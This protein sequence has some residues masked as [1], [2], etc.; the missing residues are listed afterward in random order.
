MH[1]LCLR[2]QMGAVHL[3]LYLTMG[4]WSQLIMPA[5]WLEDKDWGLIKSCPQNR[6]RLLKVLQIIRL[7][8]LISGPM[9]PG[10]LTPIE[11]QDQTTVPNPIA[12][13]EKI[14][15]TVSLVVIMDIFFILNQLGYCQMAIASAL[16]DASFLTDTSVEIFASDVVECMSHSLTF[17]FYVRFSNLMRRE[18]MDFQKRCRAGVSDLMKRIGF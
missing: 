9:Q 14:Y 15:D 4:G 1:W 16:K 12:N 7:A 2:F 18:F 11:D 17:Y 8:N 3:I 13:K 6:Q 5:D 10:G